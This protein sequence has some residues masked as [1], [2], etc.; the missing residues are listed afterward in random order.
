MCEP[1]NCM[2]MGQD[3]HKLVIHSNCFTQSST[4]YASVLDEIYHLP[5]VDQN[6]QVYPI[7]NQVCKF[8]VLH[9]I[10][11][12]PPA[13]QNNHQNKLESYREIHVRAYKNCC[14]D[15]QTVIYR[16]KVVLM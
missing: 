5:L 2:M 6:N 14:I 13:D 11:H 15:V 4:K 9:E 8:S 7:I 10:Y 12:L 1:H 16:T 3:T